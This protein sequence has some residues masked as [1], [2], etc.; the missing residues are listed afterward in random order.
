MPAI[1]GSET[2]NLSI[3]HVLLEFPLKHLRNLFKRFV[4][5]YLLRDFNV[6]TLQMITGLCLFLFG[7]I[8][9]VKTW[10]ENAS[11]DRNTPVGTV[12]LATLPIIIGFQ[13]LL[14]ALSFDI[15]NVPSRPIQQILP[16]SS[17]IRDVSQRASTPPT[18]RSGHA[19][20]PDQTG[21]RERD[22]R[23]RPR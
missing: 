4:Y 19:A 2:S 1:Y 3:G 6:G 9:G 16:Q 14:A 12:M 21:P 5:I 7:V 17:L 20:L 18:P 23:A 10:I 15:A 13:L 11:V 22:R 8:F